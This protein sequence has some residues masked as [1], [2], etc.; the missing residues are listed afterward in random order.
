MNLSGLNRMQKKAVETVDG[1]LLI[2][3]G[4]GSGK[5]KV[6]TSRIAYLIDDCGVEPYNI[7]AITFTNKAAR[8]MKE[9]VDAAVGANAGKVWVSTFHSTCVRI[10]RRYID[11]IGY[12]TNF[13]IY[14]TEDQKS[15]IKDICK[16]FNIDTK[17]L[18]ERSIMSAI[19]KAKDELQSPSD[20][21]RNVGGDYNGKRIANVYREYQKQLRLNNA[22][23]F[24]DI[25]YK[26]VELFEKDEEVLA[27][28]QERFQY[29]MV[30]EY[31]D[32][33]TSQFRLISLLADKYRN[34]CVVGDDD[35]SIYK[36]R[37][38][39]ITNILSFESTFDGAK[40][41]KLEQ[42]Y[43][44]TQT[45]LNVA[46]A[47]IKNN[48]GRKDKALW[49]ENGEGD[50]VNFSLYDS[51]FAE[52]EG[53]V[54]SIAEKVRDGWDY[55][56]IAILY[57][58]NAQ[59]RVLEEK[60]LMR[61]IP[62]RIYGGVSFYQ[63]KEIKDILSY[64]K[65]I[66][67][68]SDAQAIKRIINIPK[69]GIGDTTIA[70]ISEYADVN[71]MTFWDALKNI[72]DIATVKR[73]AN[74]I[75]PFTDLIEKFRERLEEISLRELIE[76]ILEETRYIDSLLEK[77]EREEVEARKENI[78]ELVTKVVSYENACE[79]EGVKATLNGFLE[80]VALIA[81]IDNLDE[82]E[83]QVMLMTLHSAKGLEFPIV[84]MTGMEDGLFPSYMTIT[85]DDPTEI[86][87][88]RRL[89]YVGITRAKKE[90]FLSAAKMRMIRGE[91][92][93]CKVSRFIGEIPK[94]YLN[95]ENNC[96]GYSNKTIKFGGDEDYSSANRT[97]FRA[98]GK[99]ML[100]AYGS[101]KVSSDYESK[102]VTIGRAYGNQNRSFK[103]DYGSA[104]PNGVGYRKKETG[105]SEY[106]S[107]IRAGNLSKPN[108]KVGFGKEFPMDLFDLKKD[109][110]HKRSTSASAFKTSGEG[111]SAGLGGIESLGYK[112]GDRVCHTKFGEG[113]VRAIE[114]SPRDFMV[115]VDFD[116][117]GT[118]RMLSQF[119]KLKLK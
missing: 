14:D 95:T 60:L 24:D 111:P 64:L 33:N 92:Q 48:Y 26:T 117:F 118:K 49:T 17:M 112:V 94:E 66:D 50:L 104:K 4:A 34:L 39:N 9:R 79:E 62:Y 69:R 72:D 40:V 61:N 110:A 73:G 19:S 107:D 68:A 44:S 55:N 90:L 53:V 116:E 101:G 8:E 80:E 93:S 71:E 115:T 97:N 12:N 57:R 6:L 103:T 30:D 22:L 59:S 56:D 86:E 1:P 78:N 3:A 18:K 21:E 88:E 45:I 27:Y 29:I 84:Y 15:V 76:E 113:I 43:R 35:Q 58:T 65:T 70:N 2:I 16:K 108:N 98:V 37:G 100:S 96:Q 67:N 87:E 51:G 47:V 10:L 114:E 91:T 83:K 102:R 7:L 23:D 63:R 81:D 46:N 36:F 32:T 105:Y 25:I 42:N 38:A 82:S 41:I 109:S 85:S 77:E 89:C 20:Y 99:S 54:A 52:A 28:Y 13:T 5:T 106:A 75:K 11:R 31:Q 119:A 74:K